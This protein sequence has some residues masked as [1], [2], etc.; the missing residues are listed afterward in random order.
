MMWCF[1]IGETKLYLVDFC[2]FC[3]RLIGL[4]IEWKRSSFSLYVKLFFSVYYIAGN[5][6]FHLRNKR[7]KFKIPNKNY[8]LPSSVLMSHFPSS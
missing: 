6:N 1:E 4:N 7:T 3:C 5:I 8:S 2:E